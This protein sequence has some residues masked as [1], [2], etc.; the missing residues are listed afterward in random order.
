MPFKF[1]ILL[2]TLVKRNNNIGRVKEYSC[3]IGKQSY[4]WNFC[5]KVSSEFWNGYQFSKAKR[6]LVYL[7][8]TSSYCFIL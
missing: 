4:C 7:F 2:V 5:Y 8:S 6:D 3:I 1:L